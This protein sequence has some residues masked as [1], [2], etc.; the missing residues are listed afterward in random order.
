M[1]IQVAPSTPPK[2]LEKRIKAVAEDAKRIEEAK[3]LCA[4]VLDQFS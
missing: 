3:A 4:E 2:V 1:E